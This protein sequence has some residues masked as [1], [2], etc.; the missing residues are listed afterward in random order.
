MGIEKIDP[1]FAEKK[2]TAEGELLRYRLPC[3]GFDLYGIWFDEKNSCFVRMDIDVASSVS[4]QLCHLVKNVSGGR[5]RF[6][7][8]SKYF[9]VE[10]TYDH[11][12]RFS[13]MP[14]LG[15]CGMILLEEC[16]D[17][18]L[19]LMKSVQ[20]SFHRETGYT[21]TATLR[22]GKMRNYI[23]YLP[24]YNWINTLHIELDATAIV[25]GGKKYRD[26]LPILYYGSSIT[27][28]GC[29][30]RPDNCYQALISKWNEI[31]YINLGFSG[32]G[33]GEQ[34]VA[35]YLGKIPCSLFV[36]DYDYNAPDAEYLEQTH[37]PFYETFRK[38]QPDTPIL[39]IS[40]PNF[41][42]SLQNSKDR[43]AVIRRSYRKAREMGD[44]KVYFL[45]GKTLFGKTDWINCTVDGVHP[46]DL[47]FYRMAKKI[48]GKM[49][50]IDQKFQ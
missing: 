7:T 36:M 29:A 14:L 17:G 26:E 10:V 6:S 5:V 49:K 30:S 13:H 45:S 4:D 25:T 28:G 22:G 43:E 42:T 16:E 2:V 12:T 27:Q 40:R 50:Q 18:S 47:G 20:P 48:Y 44:E 11:F 46:N 19:R 23:L 31:D 3:K 35:E 37:F 1:N 15:S 21:S 24:L 32:N 34:V 41:Y 33:R 38:L 8:D 39:F 9:C